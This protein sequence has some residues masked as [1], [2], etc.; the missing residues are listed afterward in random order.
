[1]NEQLELG[2][3]FFDLSVDLCSVFSF[4]FQNLVFLQQSVHPFGEL[5]EDSGLGEM[6]H[7]E[8]LGFGEGVALGMKDL[9]EHVEDT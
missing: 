5:F 4:G 9:H 3:M 7:R 6:A 2:L 1:M 8:H